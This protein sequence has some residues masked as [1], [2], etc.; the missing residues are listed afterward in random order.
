M[1]NVSIRV[2]D[3]V[4]DCEWNDSPTANLIHAALPIDARGNYWGG[5]IYFEIPV[6]APRKRAP[7]PSSS[8]EPSLTGPPVTASVSSGDLPRQ[9]KVTSA[10]RQAPST[11]SGESSTPKSFRDSRPATYASKPEP[12][13]HFSPPNGR[14]TRYER[15]DFVALACRAQRTVQVRLRA[16]SGARLVLTALSRTSPRRVVRNAG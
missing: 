12:S 14:S 6:Q 13:L 1:Y 10:V 9:A 3:I 8:P 5:E 15:Q 7:A 11:S 4:L 2:G 16:P